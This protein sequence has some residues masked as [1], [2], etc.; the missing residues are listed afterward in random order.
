MLQAA[1]GALILLGIY[2][3]M[4]SKSDYEID[5][6]MAFVFILAPGLLIFLLSIAL[7]YF[8]LTPELVLLGYLLYFLVPFIYLKTL[9]D[10]ETK[11]AFNFSI[12]VPIVA[13]L[14]EIPFLFLS[15]V[16]NS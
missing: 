4:N 2:K 5:W 3:F 12:V 15:G 10:Y 6:T 7:N 1:L 8:E 11:P 13:A 9:L 16:P 14:T